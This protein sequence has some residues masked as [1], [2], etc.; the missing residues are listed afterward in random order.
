MTLDKVREVVRGYQRQ[1]QFEPDDAEKYDETA[2]LGAHSAPAMRHVAYMCSE[3]LKMCDEGRT[4]KVMRWLGFMQGVLWGIGVYPL[5]AL[6]EQN[7]PTPADTAAEVL[8]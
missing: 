8:P 3:I 4:E 5:S 2:L 7:T 1:F 6:K